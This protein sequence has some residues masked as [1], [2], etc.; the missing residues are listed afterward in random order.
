MRG[1]KVG[2]FV[3]WGIFPDLLAFGLPFAVFAA[4]YLS[5]GV[6]NFFPLSSA[7]RNLPEN[8]S[9][10]F[11]WIGSFYPLG[12]SLLVF[13]AIFLILKIIF[14]KFYWGMLGW[15]LHIVIDIFSHSINLY[16]TPFLWPISEYRFPYG[17]Q[18]SGPVFMIANYSLLLIFFSILFLRGGNRAGFFKLR[19][20]KE[21]KPEDDESAG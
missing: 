18:W 20:Y 19:S 1:L 11:S 17:A 12:H 13:A 8:F 14:R 2:L 6:E 3:F 15:P 21:E 4:N 16:P 5:G 10:V 7:I 9:W